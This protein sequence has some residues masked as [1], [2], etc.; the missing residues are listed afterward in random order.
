MK[1]SKKPLT[2]PKDGLLKN[3]P[4]RI[5]EAMRQGSIKDSDNSTRKQKLK[6]VPKIPKPTDIFTD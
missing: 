2:M 6:L 4:T 1:R 3:S 5:G